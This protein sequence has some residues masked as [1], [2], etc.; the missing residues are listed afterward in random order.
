MSRLALD[1]PP[2][3]AAVEGRVRY[4]FGLFAL[5][6]GH[7]V[8]PG[9]RADHTLTYGSADLPATSRWRPLDE[10]APTPEMWRDLPVHHPLVDGEPDL[11][12]EIFE[13]ASL[14]HEA[15][16]SAR[17]DAGRIPSSDTLAI[18]AGLSP[19]IPWASRLID[20]LQRRLAERH[21]LVSAPRPLG[22]GRRLIGASHDVD[23]LPTSA[24]DTAR[25]IA[26][27]STVGA[28]RFGSRTH[29]A[30]TL[31]VGAIRAARGELERGP[32]EIARREHALGIR[33]TYTWLTRDGHPRDARYI[34]SGPAFADRLERIAALGH[35][36]AVHGSYT[37]LERPAR[38][39]AEYTR[40]ERQGIV[41]HGSRQ[42]WLRYGDPRD[43]V[44]ELERAGARYDATAG[45]SDRIGFRT[46]IAHPHPLYDL[47][48]DRPSDVV[49]IPTPIMDVAVADRS[50]TAAEWRAE[51]AD[52][53]DAVDRH[54]LGG[55]SVLWH[56]P[57]LSG[58]QLPPRFGDLYWELH[59]EG[60]HEW[61]TLLE[62]ERAVR[63][64]LPVCGFD[65]G[66]AP[67]TP[68]ATRPS[69]AEAG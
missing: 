29:A 1:V 7:E 14:A 34:A 17:D 42:H 31:T 68:R 52:V 45:F 63:E 27:W 38:L 59:G 13:W 48:D 3:H 30:R 10:P 61:V 26:V 37:S 57:V 64:R 49:E 22:G 65:L 6:H 55:V 41:A 33:A 19:T 56:D 50:T 46:G 2:A 21:A 39:A 44:T 20:A 25:R 23:F 24:R 12:A 9:A 66:R 62:I 47:V 51:C 4:A 58:F 69:P 16:T 32:V 35:E 11:L 43:L 60:R 18:R 53:L 54:R 5:A 36:H 28:R 15:A 67:V 8:V 40:L